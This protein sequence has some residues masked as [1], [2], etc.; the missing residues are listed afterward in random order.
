MDRITRFTIIAVLGLVF[1]IGTLAAQPR[2]SAPID[3]LGPLIDDSVRLAPCDSVAIM[4]EMI[5]SLWGVGWNG[6]SKSALKK[7]RMLSDSVRSANRRKWNSGEQLLRVMLPEELYHSWRETRDAKLRLLLWTTS[8]AVDD[9]RT[10]DVSSCILVWAQFRDTVGRPR[11]ALGRGMSHDSLDECHQWKIGSSP[12]GSYV[13]GDGDNV[14]YISIPMI[15]NEA[16]TLQG[17]IDTSNSPVLNDSTRKADLEISVNRARIAEAERISR[18]PDIQVYDHAPTNAEIYFFLGD[19]GE[20]PG[21]P[22]APVWTW[23]LMNRRLGTR[24]GE[25]WSRTAAGKIWR[26]EWRKSVGEY[27]VREFKY[28]EREE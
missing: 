13:V 5:A 20:H 10:E 6:G 12:L 8:K 28:L 7:Y 23:G 22:N 2:G 21:H 4:R 17:G 1:C 25:S 24:K 3:S 11:W 27:P 14:A 16:R 18:S 15:K 9:A 26:E 19:S